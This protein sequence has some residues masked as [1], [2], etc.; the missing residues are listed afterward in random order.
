LYCPLSD[1]HSNVIRLIVKKQPPIKRFYKWVIKKVIKKTAK[2]FKQLSS[3]LK[4]KKTQPKKSKVTILK[5]I[6][7]ILNTSKRFD[8]KSKRFKVTILKEIVNIL[9]TSKRFD[10]KSKPKAPV[11]PQITK[12]TKD[13][14][15]KLFKSTYS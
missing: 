3:A 10:K 15:C 12:E 13:E 14:R 8:K 11:T 1:I 5:E 4:K 6:V 2:R 7:N 9:N